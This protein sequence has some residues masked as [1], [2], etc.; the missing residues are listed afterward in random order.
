MVEGKE[1]DED[2]L[3]CL[4]SI[5]K[6]EGQRNKVWRQVNCHEG[7]GKRNPQRWLRRASQRGK[8]KTRKIGVMSPKVGVAMGM[9]AAENK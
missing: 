3:R 9:Q 2:H 1:V 4:C 7:Q 8:R 6:D 5:R